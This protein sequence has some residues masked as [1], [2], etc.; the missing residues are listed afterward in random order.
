MNNLKRIMCAVLAVAGISAMTATST[1]VSAYDNL[2]YGT[3]NIPYADFYA[4]EGV[5]SDVD[6]VSSA[7]TSK[8]KNENLTAGTFNQ[9]NED[10][11]G[12]ILGVTYNVA[13]TRETLNALGDNNYNFVES[14]E[15]PSAYKL[16]TVND[17]TVDFSAIVGNTSA[18]ENATA[19]ISSSTPWGD[20]VIGITSIHNSNGTS[21][22][23]RIYGAMLTTANGDVYA[24]RHLQNIWRDE[25]AWSSGFKTTEPHG[26]TLDYED[27]VS[28][29]GQTIKTITYITETGYHTIDTE[30]YV[31]V[32]FENNF[33]VENAD[34]NSGSTKYI[35]NGLPADYSSSFEIAELDATV[36]ND[37][38]AFKNAKPGSYTISLKDNSG[39]YDSLSASFALTTDN[40]PVKADNKGLK[41]ANGFTAD[42]FANYVKN[43]KTVKVDDK[44]YSASGRGAVK[45]IN[46]DGTINFDAANREV[47]VFDSAKSTFKITV[48]ATG[49]NNDFGFVVNRN[50][51]DPKPTES[52]VATQPTE[53]TNPTATD[54]TS[55]TE[56][57]KA[58]SSTTATASK[59]STTAPTKQSSNTTSSNSNGTVATGNVSTIVYTLIA[60][61]GVCCLVVYALKR[62]KSE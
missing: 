48:S 20:Y 2:V 21:D 15:I 60:L 49:Y 5:S 43:I 44:E 17:N 37:T 54:A 53:A 47:P 55:A 57:T 56:S 42:D 27:Y 18:V 3:M 1:I 11:T 26:S 16:V 39:K 22:I 62:K 40:T 30:L 59:N 50:S 51:D 12:T 34:I 7:T 45:I 9:E 24:M 4:N 29:M 33:S 35:L 32:K 61:M 19:S 10:G 41:V 13:L 38:I 8:W 52:T 14:T 36:K 58:T 25:L 31:P 28:L 23:G 46:E 6:A